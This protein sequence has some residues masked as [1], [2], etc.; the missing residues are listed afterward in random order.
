[1]LGPTRSSDYS[2][3]RA[4]LGLFSNRVFELREWK[5]EME[6]DI[7]DLG[8]CDSKWTLSPEIAVKL[9]VLPL[10]RGAHPKP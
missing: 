8:S 10:R 1:M 4:G 3:Y 6:A 9:H 2:S 5:A 7:E